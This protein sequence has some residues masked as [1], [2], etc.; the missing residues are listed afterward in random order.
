M[1]TLVTGAMLK[2]AVENGTFIKGGKV[3]S[4]EAVKYDFHMGDR[5]L[6]AFYGQP[7]DIDSI[8][9]ER[10]T[11]DPGEVV[12][13]LSAERLDLPRSM[14]AVLTP[15]R[16]LA[17]GGIIMLG[18]LAVDPKYKG[19][20]VIGLYNF[21]ST[22]YP[23]IPGSKLIGSVFYT[24]QDK[25]LE[26]YEVADPAEI[27]D[28]PP[29]LIYLIQNYK[30]IALKGIQEDIDNTKAELS[31]LKKEL[32]DDKGW[33]EDFKKDLG[34]HNKQLGE[35]IAGLKE[36]RDARKD[37]DKRISDRLDQKSTLFLGVRWGT[38]GV[39]SVLGIGFTALITALV[40]VFVT[41]AV[42]DRSTIPPPPVPRPA[43]SSSAPAAL[44]S[45]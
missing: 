6:K 25:E 2:A 16:T 44:K 7:K 27:V 20:L 43:A 28:F 26:E 35:L 4:V 14:M 37:E 21:S 22:A 8:P 17:H 36:E 11:V 3:A 9:E 45:P 39:I 38:I 30:P 24:L 18:G 15:K 19:V 10:R 42:Q 5:V 40:T 12:F 34:E 1:T 13:V 23:L 41:H 31:S 32:L 29:Q 33:R